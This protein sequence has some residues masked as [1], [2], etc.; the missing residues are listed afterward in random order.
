MA[1][2]VI[3]QPV[4][5]GQDRWR[6]NPA[7]RKRGGQPGPR[8]GTR[9]ENLLKYMKLAEV[10]K[11]TPSAQ[12]INAAPRSEIPCTRTLVDYFGSLGALQLAAGLPMR[13]KGPPRPSHCQRGHSLAGDGI[14]VWQSRGRRY[15]CCRRCR[16][17]RIR[18]YNAAR[19]A[20][21]ATGRS[22]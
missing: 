20:K 4:D 7:K 11:R 10:L 12:D 2:A 15:R 8:R 5:V 16:L 22:A 13:D 19:R 17:L 6:P 21:R 18:I 9:D 14:Y 3:F 1:T